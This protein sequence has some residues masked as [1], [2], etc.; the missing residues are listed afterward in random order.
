MRI[1]GNVPTQHPVLAG[2]GPCNEQY[3]QET[4]TV[5]QL[6]VQ[7]ATPDSGLNEV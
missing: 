6:Q 5:A 3:P 7:V 4:Q 2:V 1:L